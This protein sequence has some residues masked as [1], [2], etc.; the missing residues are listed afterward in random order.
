MWRETNDILYFLFAVLFAWH[1]PHKLYPTAR[2]LD[3]FRS[4][5]AAV[6]RFLSEKGEN[7]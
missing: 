6:E 2:S 3:L 5:Y 7:E 1:D 4:L